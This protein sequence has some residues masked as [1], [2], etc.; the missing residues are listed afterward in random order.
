MRDLARS[1]VKFQPDRETSP[2]PLLPITG[3]LGSDFRTSS[4]RRAAMAQELFD[5]GDGLAVACNAGGRHHGWL[6]QK[7]PNGQYVSLRKL[8]LVW[9]RQLVS[10]F[11]SVSYTH[12]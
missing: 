5:L 1:V 3:L 7:H 4:R 8:D 2:G 11:Q 6:F 10:P 9:P 12:L